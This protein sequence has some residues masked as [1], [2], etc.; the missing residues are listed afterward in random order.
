MFI[1]LGKPYQ[2]YKDN[3]VICLDIKDTN[4]KVGDLFYYE[5]QYGRLHRTNVIDIQE[6]KKSL[7]E[8]SN[9]KIGFCLSEAVPRNKEI[10]I[11]HKEKLT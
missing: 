8:V 9:G 6:N 1:K 3:K 4:V 5:D 2:Y 11:K 7:S 10:M